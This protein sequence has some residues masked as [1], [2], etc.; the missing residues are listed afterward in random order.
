SAVYGGRGCGSQKRPD[1]QPASAP[2]DHRRFGGTPDHPTCE[3]RNQTAS[4]AV[5]P[6]AGGCRTD[7]LELSTAGPFSPNRARGRAA[8]SNKRIAKCR[9][10][11]PRI[12]SHARTDAFSESSLAD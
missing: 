11:F 5:L 6:E 9:L 8:G 2:E 3:R 7:H 12:K 4:R 1:Q 10:V